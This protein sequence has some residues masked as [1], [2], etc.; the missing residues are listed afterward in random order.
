MRNA[1]YEVRIYSRAIN[2]RL[3]IIFIFISLLL[4]MEMGHNS[5]EVSVIVSFEWILI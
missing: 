5:R 2:F 1:A 4:Y 3:T